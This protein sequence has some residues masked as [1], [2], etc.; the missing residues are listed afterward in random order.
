MQSSLEKLRKF[1]RLEHGNGYAN[2]A[3][4]GGLAKILDYWEG[5][6]RNEAVPEPLIQA[7]ASTLRLYADQTPEVRRLE[8]LSLWKQ[9]Q[10]EYPEA[11]PQKKPVPARRNRSNQLLLPSEPAPASSLPLPSEAALRPPPLLPFLQFPLPLFPFPCSPHPC[12][13][14]P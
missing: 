11:A 7:V 14:L 13:P 3:V 2:T 4:I 10:T 1:F 12:S 8:L 9:V 6:A 5:E